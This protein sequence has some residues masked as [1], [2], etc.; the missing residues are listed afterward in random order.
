MTDMAMPKDK[1]PCHE[2]D[3]YGGPFLDHHCYII[4]LSDLYLGEEKKIFK[5]IMHFYYVTYM[6]TP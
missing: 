4:S 2:I 6:A 1:N 5:E 3:N